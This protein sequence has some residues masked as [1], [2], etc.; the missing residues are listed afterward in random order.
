LQSPGTGGIE[1]LAALGFLALLALPP[2]LA[3]SRRRK[4]E[5]LPDDDP[6]NK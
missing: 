3:L 2:T 5:T 1:L 6:G 4:S